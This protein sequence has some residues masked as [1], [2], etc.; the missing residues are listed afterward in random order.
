MPDLAH[1]VAPVAETVAHAIA[2]SS[3]KKIELRTPL[4]RAKAREAQTPGSSAPK[5]PAR[6]PAP[7]PTCR[8]CGAALYERRRKLCSSCWS[9]TRKALAEQR[10]GA[11]VAALAQARADRTDPTHSP[12]AR[13][14][15]HHSLVT[16]KNAE[17]AWHSRG[18]EPLT[19]EN[20]LQVFV[21]PRLK[22]CTIRELQLATGFSGSSLDRVDLW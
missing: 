1:A 11:G 2:S 19:S 16:V 17:A 10:A 21:L 8:S 9:V 15:R 4:T 18:Q 7:M 3:L 14:K 5:G 13:E 6:T 22:E 12:A 20:E